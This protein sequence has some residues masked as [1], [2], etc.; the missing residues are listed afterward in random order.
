[1]CTGI[2][3]QRPMQYY[4]SI[5]YPH[6]NIS[7]YVVVLVIMGYTWVVHCPPIDNQ[8]LNPIYYVFIDSVPAI[9]HR[10]FFFHTDAV[11]LHFTFALLI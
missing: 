9:F 11:H 6:I 10:E 4:Y 8:L 2:T 1:M 5:T 7:V 3:H